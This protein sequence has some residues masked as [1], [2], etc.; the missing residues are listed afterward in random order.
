MHLYIHIPF[1]RQAC[2]YCDFHFSTNLKYKSEMVDAI[3]KEIE[4]QSDYLSNKNIE[5]I[6]FG[7]GTPS[8]LTPSELDKILETVHKY[9]ICNSQVECTIEANPDD[10]DRDK[11]LI[12]KQLGVNR[13]SIGIQTFDEINLKYTNRVHDAK[14]AENCVKIAQD[15]DF[16][17]ITID[18]IY[19][20]N[21]L[22]NEKKD[23][24]GIWKKDLEKALSLN[25][26]HISS[27][28]LTIEPQT[29]F[30]KWQKVN[31]IPPIDEEFATEQFKIL[32]NTLESAGYEQYEISNFARNQMY[33]R[34]NTSY[35]KDHEYLG[36]GPS[37]HSYNGSSRQFNVSNNTK[38]IKSINEGKIS[39]DIEILTPEN[40]VND[41]L[42]T[43]LRTK[44]GCDL[45]KIVNIIGEKW[46]KENQTILE[47]YINNNLLLLKNSVLLLTNE[48]KFFADR[49]ASDL[50]LV[51]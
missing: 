16:Q 8:I 26:P 36:I 4:L 31:K 47:N 19:A 37:A 1:C 33:S 42:L 29:V 3:C 30:G 44:W 32:I 12:F 43:S 51:D 18:L 22:E 7:G 28:C 6:Y 13:L 41:Y 35:W 15:A 46:H 38:Y 11:L 40:K 10:I 39:A 17:N 45:N 9:Y 5:T 23:I 14:E 49:I 2:H 27:Y 50:F 25:V 48:G 21:S 34:H 20:I 24:H